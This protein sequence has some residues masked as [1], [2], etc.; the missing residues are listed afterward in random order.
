MTKSD[1]LA[2]VTGA[3]GGLGGAIAR[4]LFDDGLRVALVDLDGTAAEAEAA[5]LSADASRAR[6]FACDVADREQVEAALRAIVE[7]FGEPYALVNCAGI[8]TM[9]PIL[10]IT[11]EDWSRVIGINLN[12]TFWFSQ[13]VGRR[14]VAAGRGRI[15]NIASISGERAG[16]GRAAYGTSK[17]GVIHLTRQFALELAPFGIN[18]NAVAPGP[19]DTELT[20]RAY[21]P[22]MRASYDE[23]IPQ[24]RFGQPEEMAA[25]VAFL[26][27][28]EAGYVNGHTLV[29]DGGFT[30]AGVA[31]GMAHAQAEKRSADAPAE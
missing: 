21:T 7:A 23:L 5:K 8:G 31:V 10:E 11:P 27:S 19:V 9:A 6:G 4:R 17:A 26:C 29:V 22:E 3:A 2:I 12:G 20:R 13:A 24:R 14:L 30:A 15:V 25:A 18:V 28:E 16:F 1:R